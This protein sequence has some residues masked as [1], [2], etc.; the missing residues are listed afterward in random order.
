MELTHLNKLGLNPT[1]KDLKPET[2]KF[3]IK[4]RNS[5]TIFLK[6]KVYPHNRLKNSK[7]NLNKIKQISWTE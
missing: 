4:N 3:W 7:I 1:R 5:K 6:L 2:L